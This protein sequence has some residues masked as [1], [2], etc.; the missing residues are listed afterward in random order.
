MHYESKIRS[1]RPGE[2]KQ[3]QELQITCLSST[4]KKK[5]KKFLYHLCEFYQLAHF[6]WSFPVLRS[7]K[8]ITA[9]LLQRKPQRIT[10]LMNP[11]KTVMT[12]NSFK[13]NSEY[14]TL[15][16]QPCTRDPKADVAN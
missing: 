9:F 10:T 7:N 4:S 11:E 5:W 15:Q 8:L 2:K 12:R 16:N 13:W 3:N 1:C 6:C 14:G